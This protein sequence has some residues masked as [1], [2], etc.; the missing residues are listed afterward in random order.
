VSITVPGSLRERKKALTRQNL[1][2]AAERLFEQHGYDAVTVAEIADAANVSVKTLFVYFR[3][4]EELAFADTGL[5]D[6]MVDRLRD[7]P[8]RRTDA[9]TVADVLIERLRSEA[10]TDF[11]GFQRG[12]GESTALESGLRRMW[13]DWEDRVTA[14]LAEH[15]GEI[16]G[17]LTRFR[18]IQLVGLVR[19]TASAE[20]FTATAGGAA[21]DAAERV[22]AWITEAAEALGRG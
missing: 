20:A 1:I 21:G 16:A 6:E 10:D 13:N 9:L 3:S 11:G 8:N 18:A 17:P 4:K 2:D 22:E 19:M 7:R 5:I 14:V 12:Y 15:A